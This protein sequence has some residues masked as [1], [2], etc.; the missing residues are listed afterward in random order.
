MAVHHFAFF[1]QQPGLLVYVLHT[2]YGEL[3]R[4]MI[5]LPYKRHEVTGATEMPQWKMSWLGVD[6]SLADTYPP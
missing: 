3:L 4:P 1:C 2:S 5:G 6:N